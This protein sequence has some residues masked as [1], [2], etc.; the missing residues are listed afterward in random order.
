LATG[1]PA[2]SYSPEQG[3]HNAADVFVVGASGHQA[4]SHRIEG[5]AGRDALL[6]WSSGAPWL[7]VAG[8]AGL[9]PVGDY[10]AVPSSWFSAVAGS[11]SGFALSFGAEAA[12]PIAVNVVRGGAVIAQGA[13]A[14]T[15]SYFG[16]SAWPFLA[17][18][19]GD[20]LILLS[21]NLRANPGLCHPSRFEVASL[22]RFDATSSYQ[23]AFD[24]PGE[25]A[26]E[27]A[28]L[29]DG[30]LVL[31]RRTYLNQSCT[32][33]VH[34]VTIEAYALVGE[35]LAPSGWVQREGNRGL[36]LRPR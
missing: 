17:G 10:V 31:G 11:D 25:S 3:Y 34:P 7:E 24:F 19:A 8:S 32:H 13:V 22:S 16:I 27:G 26:I 35:S 12:S 14:G 20:H 15:T 30:R 5:P 23:C 18:A 4:W 6:A 1:N 33:D 21:Q 2:S 28:A 9:S 36:G 29:L